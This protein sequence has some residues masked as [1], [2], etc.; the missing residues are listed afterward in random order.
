M[1]NKTLHLQK[2]SSKGVLMK[3]CSESMQQIYS[4]AP[5]PKC[6]FKATLLK[7]HFDIGIPL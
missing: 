2:Q 1:L 5:M 7:S 6:D 4:R 3:R